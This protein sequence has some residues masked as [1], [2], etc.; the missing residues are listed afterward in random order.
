M[1]NKHKQKDVLVTMIT[2]LRYRGHNL[3]I[4][5]PH[6]R[7]QEMHFL[8]IAELRVNG[9]WRRIIGKE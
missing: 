6:G 9:D 8:W 2:F 3:W 7:G 1:I 5:F 4:V